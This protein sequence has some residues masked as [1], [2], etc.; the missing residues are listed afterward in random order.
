MCFDMTYM[1]KINNSI[2]DLKNELLAIMLLKRF[3]SDGF[4][5]SK[6]KLFDQKASN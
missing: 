1:K 4:L 6:T 2:V 5:L 3:L